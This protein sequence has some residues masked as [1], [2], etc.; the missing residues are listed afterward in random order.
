MLRFAYALRREGYRLVHCFFNDSSLIAPFF[1][2]LAG[3]RVLVSRRDM[4]IWY[5]PGVLR[6]LRFVSRFVDRYVAN[7]RMVGRHVQN[8]E[9]V[10]AERI[11]VIYNGY[12]AYREDNSQ[13][14]YYPVSRMEARSSGSSPT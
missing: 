8:Q 14:H 13:S 6:I 9:R 4:G 10:S 12:E 5:T 2:K 3:L 1:L 7:S 11:T